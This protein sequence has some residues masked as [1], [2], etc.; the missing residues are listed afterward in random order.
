MLV[1]RTCQEEEMKDGVY[2]TREITIYVDAIYAV[3]RTGI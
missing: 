3:Y 2:D 1:Y